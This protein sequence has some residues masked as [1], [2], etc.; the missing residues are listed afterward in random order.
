MNSFKFVTVVWGTDFTDNFLK[1]C[2]PSQLFPG[3]L[4]YFA[5][6][7]NSI[8]RIYTTTKDAEVIRKSSAYRNLLTIMPVEMAVISGM[9][10]VAKYQVMTQCHAHF[11]RSAANDD[12]A[13][14]FMSPDVVW[15]DGSFARLLEI[16][17]SGKLMV[18]A[19]S[20]R[21][22]KETFI[23]D[24]KKQYSRNDILQ[25]ITSRQLVKL[26]LGHLHPVTLSEFWN[27]NE[28]HSTNF[29]HLIWLVKD[30][31]LIVRQFHLFPLLVKSVDKDAVPIRSTDADYSF[32]AC[33]NPDDVYVVQ[34]SDEMCFM[35]FT[36]L[37]Q[38]NELIDHKN[39]DHIQS[40]E[41]VVNWA[42]QNT[43]K[44]HLEFVKQRIRF[45]WADC[46][47]KWRDIEQQ[48]DA[49]VEATLSLIEDSG[50]ASVSAPLSKRRYL[51]PNFLLGKVRQKGAIGF[52][53]QVFSTVV[54]P[55]LRK[56]YGHNIKIRMVTDAH[57]VFSKKNDAF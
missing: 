24:L 9:S 26:A 8:Y 6:H 51:S 52:F 53:K 55:L 2:L 29:G 33:P 38:L 31:G 45:H 41:N 36:G 5:Q 49:V 56:I 57:T 20:V 48:S 50:N 16:Y 46:S 21:L 3:N 43:H 15:A 25:P 42:N 22:L 1:V 14:V 44:L 34:D 7:T 28:M 11:I 54:Q 12:C 39:P 37:S 27:V 23:P 18:V 40:I 13:F 19:G 30:E 35:D 10:Y 47:D 32:K 17:E 4:V